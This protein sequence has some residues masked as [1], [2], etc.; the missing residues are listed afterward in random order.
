MIHCSPFTLNVLLILPG[1]PLADAAGPMLFVA[2]FGVF[3]LFLLPTIFIAEA[4]VLLVMRWGTVWRCLLDA[5][6]ANLASSLFGFVG[7]CGVITGAE[8]DSVL[9]WVALLIV[10]WGVSI[11]I[12]GAVLRALK[13]HPTRQ[14]WLA[15][16]ITNSV[17]YALLA[18]LFVLVSTGIITL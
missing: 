10:A 1:A 15:S 18:V 14:T 2:L 12:E 11:L 6:L 7:L 3:G 13:R 5:A 4:I 17:S 8:P 16:L 9:A